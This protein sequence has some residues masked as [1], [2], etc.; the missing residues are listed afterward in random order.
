MIAESPLPT[1]R[2]EF[3][4]AIG[5]AATE[6]EL[7]LAAATRGDHGYVLAHLLAVVRTLNLAGVDFT[8]PGYVRCPLCLADTKDAGPETV[9]RVCGGMPE[10]GFKPALLFL[11][12]AVKDF[13]LSGEVRLHPYG[14]DF[15]TVTQPLDV[16]FTFYPYPRVRKVQFLG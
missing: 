10:D 13:E 5:Q 9:C 2:L 3:S 11:P 7:A 16:D 12:D 4:E 15:R 6:A 14:V 8:L 1:G